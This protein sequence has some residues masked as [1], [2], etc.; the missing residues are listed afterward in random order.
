MGLQIGIKM[1]LITVSA[2]VYA[3]GYFAFPPYGLPTNK[4]I[5]VNKTGTTREYQVS[6][7]SRSQVAVTFFILSDNIR[8]CDRNHVAP[9]LGPRKTLGALSKSKQTPGLPSINNY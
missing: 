5:E 6:L 7:N 4:S 3:D 9:Q 2:I 1:S 8:Q